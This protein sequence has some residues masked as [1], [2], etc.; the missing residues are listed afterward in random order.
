MRT[1]RN[2]EDDLTQYF[3][4]S[5]VKKTNQFE[6]FSMFQTK[7][8]LV[9]YHIFS[10][11][12][13]EKWRCPCWFS[14]FKQEIKGRWSFFFVLKSPICLDPMSKFLM[15]VFQACRNFRNLFVLVTIVPQSTSSAQKR[16]V[17]KGCKAIGA[18][19]E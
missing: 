15:K 7:F 6:Q 3:A 12:F 2:C 11:I 16:L 14:E 17:E 18:L 8:G 1:I 10:K 13:G 19:G 5:V 4:E 9:F